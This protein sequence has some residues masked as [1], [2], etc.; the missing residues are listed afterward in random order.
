MSVDGP[1]GLRALVEGLFDYAGT[2]PPASLPIQD[3][4]RTSASFPST[5]ARPWL[6]AADLVL[7]RDQL[8]TLTQEELVAA[9]FGPDRSFRWAVL[10]EAMDV[11]MACVMPRRLEETLGCLQE[12]GDRQR[13]LSLEVRLRLGP[14]WAAGLA[15]TLAELA[16]ALSKE[17]TRLVVEPEWTPEEWRLGAAEL[18]AALSS[19][20]EPRPVLKVRGAGPSAVTIPAL[21][22]V[23]G[24]VA[25]HGLAFK[26]TAGL[27][28]PVRE[29]CW[30][31]DLGFLSLA[32]GLRF[33]QALGPD[34]F[35]DEALAVCLGASWDDP[36]AKGHG[37]GFVLEDGLQWSE[38]SLDQE[39]LE[40]QVR[41]F[42]FSIG[43]CSL[44][45][46][47]ADLVRGFGG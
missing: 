45:E 40:C 9:G 6:V 41:R 24:A 46:P 32:A 20:P 5:L 36:H 26:A 39:T 18:A 7:T 15:G 33:R 27:H 3:A 8:G 22:E 12:K 21:V 44:A 38:W 10:G 11:G 23:V 14:G 35:P 47:D 42:P 1:R 43:S 17:G 19:F 37:F 30:S 28:H 2:F 25:R 31:N 34:V 16:L 4:M 29:A 13:V